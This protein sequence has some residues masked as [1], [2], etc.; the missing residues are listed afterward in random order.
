MIDGRS[1]LAIIVARGG[2]KGLPGKNLREIAGKPMV[3]W[4]VLAAHGSR[5]IDRTILSS[6]D[7]DIIAAAGVEGCDVPFRRPADLATDTASVIDVIEHALD[8]LEQTFEITVLLQAT[9]PL[10]RSEDIDGCLERMVSTGAHACVSVCPPSHAPHL[11]YRIDKLDQLLPILEN[12]PSSARR[13]DVPQTFMLN[14]AVYVAETKWLLQNQTFMT[15][16]TVAYMMPPE[17]SV[18]VDSELD[19]LLARAIVASK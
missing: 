16:T 8:R 6:D 13:Q 15:P 17:R 3:A 4:S 10:R 1:V 19:L 14:G 2:S 5:Y 9:S 12:S 7:E 11:F 18:D